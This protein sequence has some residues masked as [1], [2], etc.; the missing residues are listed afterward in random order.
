MIPALQ[1]RR[2]G[3]EHAHRP[4]PCNPL[5]RNWVFWNKIKYLNPNFFSTRWCKLLIFQTQIIWFNRIHSLKYLRSTTFGS[6]DIVIMKSEFVAKTQFL[7]DLKCSD[8]VCVLLH[9]HNMDSAFFSGFS[10]ILN[11]KSLQQ[12][13]QIPRWAGRR[14]FRDFCRV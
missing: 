8:L 7:S 5:Q 2:G 14:R 10:K 3:G 4:L 6:K 11:I 9:T 1:A 13:P 12:N